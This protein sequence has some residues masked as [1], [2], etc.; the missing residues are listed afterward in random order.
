[1]FNIPNEEAML[2][3][4]A[5]LAALASPGL[6]I[7]LYGDLGAG[8]TTFTRGFLRG[9]GHKGTVKSPTYTLVE[10][11]EL[12]GKTVYHFDLYRLNQPNEL[13]HMGIQDYFSKDSICL[14]EWPERGTGYLPKPDLSCY[15]EMDS[16]GRL[17]RI[18]AQSARGKTILQQIQPIDT[19]GRDE[20]G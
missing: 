2:R 4:G 9:L 18:E 13:D 3:F 10:P 6:V 8:K 20:H 17:C 16:E 5:Q 19:Q 12:A 7:F 11:Y 1:M 15:I 14:I